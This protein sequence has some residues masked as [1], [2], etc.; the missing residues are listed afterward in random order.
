MM[1]QLPCPVTL[2]AHACARVHAA[3]FQRG[4]VTI[5]DI[6]CNKAYESMEYLHGVIPNFGKNASAVAAIYAANTS[7]SLKAVQDCACPNCR[8]V[9]PLPPRQL[10][11][12]LAVTVYCAEPSTTHQHNLAIVQRELGLTQTLTMG[13]LAMTWKILPL[14]FTNYKGTARFSGGCDSELCS[15]GGEGDVVNT[16]T[17]DDFA[18][19]NGVSYFDVLKIDTEGF[20]SAVLEG[21]EGMLTQHKAGL[22]FFEYNVMGLWSNTTLQS[23][24]ARLQQWG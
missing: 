4:Q 22:V 9:A 23:V 6:G 19:E 3:T 18:Y 11:Q 13:S 15:L 10:T 2:H 17:V 24:T 12:K 14:A 8:D 21:A 1:Q 7:A 20:D 16:T 5:M